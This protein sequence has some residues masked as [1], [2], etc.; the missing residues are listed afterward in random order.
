MS[1]SYHRISGRAGRECRHNVGYWTGRP[2]RGFGVGAHSFD[3]TRR[4]WNTTSLADYA[5]HIAAGELPVLDEETLS[6]A[7][8][9]EEAFM[10]GLRQSC[11]LHVKSVAARLGVEYSSDWI[12]RVQ[13]LEEAG[14]IQF[15]GEILRLTSKGRLAANSVIEELLWP[16]PASTSLI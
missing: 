15:N 8:Q 1:W 10:L 4:F 16:T 11:G 6:L 2:Y 12:V 5:R 7:Q 13:Q 3:G 9:I 14:W